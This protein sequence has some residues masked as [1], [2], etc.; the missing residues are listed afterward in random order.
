VDVLAGIVIGLIA[1]WALLVVVLWLA[2]PRDVHLAELARVVPD[3]ARLVRDLLA[4]PASPVSVRL[5]LLL[6]LAWLIWPFD[7]IPEF[8]PVLGPLDDVVVAV[9]V[10]R[11]VGR[12]VGDQALRARWRGTEDGYALL[13]GLI[14]PASRS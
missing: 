5:A 4:D 11:F 3:I 10:L 12:R 14:G 2:R 13:S 7:I 8:I 9:L 6:L 1:A